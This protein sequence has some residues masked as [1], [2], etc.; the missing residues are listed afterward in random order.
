MEVRHNFPLKELTTIKVG[1]KALYY[2]EPQNLRELKEAIEFTKAYDIPLFIL[3]NG[4]NTI[5]GDIKGVVI[6]TS[7]IRGIKVRNERVHFFIE[8]LCGTPL[9][10]IVRLSLSENLGGIYKLLGFPASVGGAVSMNAGAFGAEISDFLEEVYILSWEGELVRYKREEIN[11]SYRCSPFPEKGVVFKAVFRLKKTT[12]NV[13][14]R[15]TRIRETRKKS[16]PINLPTSGSTFKNPEGSYAGKLLEQA[17]L[18]GFRLKEAGFSRKHANF[19]INYGNASFSEIKELIDIAKEK[20]Y[21][22]FGIKL[23]EE[24][25]LVESSG[26]NGWKVL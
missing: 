19:L 13:R 18:K 3:G 21:E 4:S 12:E 26:N 16:Q 15:Y 11:F 6:N 9:R 17:G 14:E 5:F 7:R 1:G 25:K 20:V 2:I 24:V 10:E 22:H 8:A 23:S